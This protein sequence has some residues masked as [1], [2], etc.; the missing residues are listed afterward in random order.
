MNIIESQRIYPAQRASGGEGFRRIVGS[1]SSLE[2]VLRRA[3]VLAKVDA[4]VLLQGETGVGKEMFARAL[5]DSGP[6]ATA[7]FVALNCGGLPRDLLA[8]ELFGYVDGA[9]TG[10]RRTG[11]IGK[12]EAADGGTLFLDEIAELPLDLQPYLLRVL[13]DGEVCPLGSHKARSVRFKLIAACNRDLRLEVQAKRFRADLFYRISV[14]TL[15]IPPLRDRKDDLPALVEHFA[16]RVAERHGL[17]AKHFQPEVLEVF[18]RCSWPGNL[19]QL[20]NVVELMT[21][22][23]E[24]ERVDLSV[25]PLEVL[26]T[27]P[28]DVDSE[29]K[30]SA[31]LGGLEQVERDTI[32]T[33]IRLHRGNLTLAARDLRISRSTIYLKLKKYGLERLLNEVRARGVAY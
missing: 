5:H 4:P 8:S 32:Q 6:R 10:A 19:R 26:E 16:A 2:Q 11:M 13:E 7:P 24:G 27:A 20:R 12:I 30:P 18:S 9:F 23:S 15:Q 14:T 25:L 29:V 28:A 17:T 22:L 31:S 21:L 3:S 33:V 1:S